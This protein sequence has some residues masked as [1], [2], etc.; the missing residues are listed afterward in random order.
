VAHPGDY[1]ILA[2]GE[3]VGTVSVPDEAV[4]NGTQVAA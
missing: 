2:D 3:R 4:R 1:R